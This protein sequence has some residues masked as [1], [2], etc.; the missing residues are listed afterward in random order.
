MKTSGMKVVFE[1]IDPMLRCLGGRISRGKGGTYT[2]NSKQAIAVFRC[3]KQATA[4]PSRQQ[5]ECMGRE[6]VSWTTKDKAGISG[7]SILIYD[8]PRSTILKGW[9]VIFLAKDK[10]KR[11]YWRILIYDSMW[12]EIRRGWPRNILGNKGIGETDGWNLSRT[13]FISAIPK[14]ERVIW[15]R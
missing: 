6:P 15:K 12:S 11:F 8:S 7:W 10:G 4:V 9:R 3:A 1:L 14:R 5:S 2:L 13:H